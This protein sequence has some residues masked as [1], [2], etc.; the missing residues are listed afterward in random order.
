ML[1]QQQIDRQMLSTLFEKI[2]G[3]FDQGAC[4]RGFRE[5]SDLCDKYDSDNPDNSDRVR[6]NELKENLED[7]RNYCIASS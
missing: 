7:I 5:M 2:V 3:I 4:E 1:M 6:I